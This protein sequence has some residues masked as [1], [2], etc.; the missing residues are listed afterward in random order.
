M[1]LP[2]TDTVVLFPDGAL[3]ADAVVLHAIPYLESSRILRLAT[4]AHG[5]VSALG[6]GA[7]KSQRRF[8]SALDLFAY[9]RAGDDAI[10]VGGGMDEGWLAGGGSAIRGLRTASGTV[11]LAMRADADRLEVTVGGSARPG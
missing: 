2:S 10:V 6:K 7:R 3:R 8:G 9:S 5:V 1:T 11:D 4:R